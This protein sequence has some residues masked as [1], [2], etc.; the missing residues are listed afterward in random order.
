MFLRLFYVIRFL[1]M[2]VSLLILP[3]IA[4]GLDSQYFVGHGALDIFNQEGFLV[5]PRWVQIWILILIGTF[6]AGFYF[7]WKHSIAR[8]AVG[9]FIFSMTMG[10]TIFGLLNLPFLGGSIAI[11]H[12][13]C[14]SPALLIFLIKRPYFNCNE[15]MSFRA[16]S[17]LM[18][19]V[20]IFSFV[21]DIKD[22][23]IYISHVAI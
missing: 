20:L 10:H 21:F 11:M 12:L 13:V 3:S 5:T 19:S 1:V 15:R 8:W 9:G 6:I 16:W 4:F 17:G 22:A 2:A 7:A 23:L 18:T 14:W